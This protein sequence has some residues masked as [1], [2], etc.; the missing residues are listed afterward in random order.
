MISE[1]VTDLAGAIAD[2]AAVELENDPV[3]FFVDMY[4]ELTCIHPFRERLDGRA[5][6]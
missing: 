1:L 6:G 3:G 2:R 4:A 5:P